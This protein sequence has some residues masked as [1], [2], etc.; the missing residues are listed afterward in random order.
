MSVME[1]HP[2]TPVRLRISQA[3]VGN[4][5]ADILRQRI[6]D[7]TLK[8]GDLLPRQDDLVAE[9]D[10]SP[11]SIR[12]A[13]RILETERL[14]SVRRGNVGGATVH[15]PKPDAAAYMLGLV[16]QTK[17]VTNEDVGNALAELEPI[18]ASVAAAD[19]NRHQNL[20]P[21]LV[22]LNESLEADLADPT[23][24]TG[25]ARRFH[26]T[27]VKECGNETLSVVVGM[28]ESLWTNYETSWASARNVDGSYPSLQGRKGVVRAH[29]ALTR[30]IDDGDADAARRLAASHLADSLQVVLGLQVEKLAVSSGA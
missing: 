23:A 27:L 25:T 16:L 28:L 8:D 30:A 3:R 14:I 22:L 1:P 11:P 4:L 20:V 12:E 26:D 2:S 13:M 9:F 10:V 5:V 29:L 21:K 24:F 6:V 15:A 18:C 7:G 17:R 19:P